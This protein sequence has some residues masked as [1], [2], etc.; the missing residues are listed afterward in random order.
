MKVV[1]RL[2]PILTMRDLQEPEHARRDRYQSGSFKPL[3]GE[4][5]VLV[6]HDKERVIGRVLEFYA[7]DDVRGRFVF[8]RCEI[9]HASPSG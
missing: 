4:T 9:N 1:V 8:A 3:L 7:A 6:N 5:P 2:A